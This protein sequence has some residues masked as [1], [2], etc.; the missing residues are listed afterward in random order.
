MGSRRTIPHSLSSNGTSLNGTEVIGS[1]RSP[2][3]S[4][5]SNVRPENRSTL[6]SVIAQLTEETQPFFEITLKSKAISENCN[7]K[8]LCVVT[9]YPVPQVTWYKDDIQLDRYCGLPKYEIF[10]NGQ[11]HSLHIYNCTVE[12][13]AIYQASATN[14]KGIVSCSGVLEVGEM[15]EFKIHQR[16]FS[17]LKQKAENKRREAQGKENQEPVRTISPDRAQRKRRSTVGGYISAPSSTE[18]DGTEEIQQK[19][20]AEVKVRTEDTSVKEVRDTNKTDSPVINGQDTK[21][22]CLKTGA[23]MYDSAQKIFT[24]L[25]PKSHFLKIKIT[26]T[27]KVPPEEKKPS[28]TVTELENSGDLM[29]V[30]G[31]S[32]SVVPALKSLKR[33]VT[34]I[35]SKQRTSQDKGDRKATKEN[36]NVQ[37][38]SPSS[39]TSPKTPSHTP[40]LH[41]PQPLTKEDT[42]VKPCPKVTDKDKAL[43]LSTDMTSQ[44]D[45][46]CD[47]RAVLPQPPCQQA[48][49]PLPQKETS[50]DQKKVRVAPPVP[51]REA[52]QAHAKTQRN[53]APVDLEH[54]AKPHTKAAPEKRLTE[55][56]AHDRHGLSLHHGP[57]KAIDKMIQDTPD[58]SRGS[59]E[60][61]TGLFTDTQKPPVKSPCAVEKSPKCN[62]SPSA[63]QSQLNT[64]IKI[65]EGTEIQLDEKVKGNEMSTL[66]A[67]STS[68]AVN[69]KCASVKS[70]VTPIS[71]VSQKEKAGEVAKE[72]DK[73]IVDTPNEDKETKSPGETVEMCIEHNQ[74]MKEHAP[75]TNKFEVSTEP[76][77]KDFKKCS[78][79]IPTI[80]SIAELLRSQINALE[81]SVHTQSAPEDHAGRDSGCS[82]VNKSDKDSETST[83][84]TQPPTIKETLMQIYN[85]LIKT[86]ELFEDEAP[87]L[88]NTQPLEIPPTVS[89]THGIIV[90]EQNRKNGPIQSNGIQV[91]E[92]GTEE[93]HTKVSTSKHFEDEPLQSNNTGVKNK[94]QTLT[95]EIKVNSEAIGVSEIITPFAENSKT[96]E[97]KTSIN[98][99]DAEQGVD[100][101]TEARNPQTERCTTEDQ[102]TV[103]LPNLT[104]E[105]SPIL[106]K[107]DSVSFPSATPQ[108][109]A[110][111][112][113]RKIHS[114]K[115]KP[116]EMEPS[117]PVSDLKPTTVT[118]STS[119]RL[120]RHSTLLQPEVEQASPK[121]KCSPLLSRKN[122]PLEIQSQLPVTENNDIKCEESCADKA[123]ND[124]YKAPQVI[125]KIR[126]ETF[127]DHSGH[128]KLW[129]QFFNVLNEST[130]IW[131]KDE[132][133]IA[134]I[135]KSAGDETQVKLA[136]A[137]AS[138]QDCGVYGCTITNEYGTDSTDFLLSAEVLNGMSLREDLGV[139]EEIEMTAL[140]FNK[141][142]ADSSMWGNKL[143]GRIMVQ[144]THLGAGFSH[145]TW[146]AKVIYGLEPVFES[147]NTCIIKVC[148]PIPYGGKG[149]GLLIE[150]NLEMVKQA[151]R[152]QNLTREYCKIFSA[153]TR[154]IEN[155]GSSLEVIPVYMMY[156]PAN[157]IPYA[158]VEADLTGVYCK[159]SGLGQSGRFE[160]SSESEVEKKCC[161]LQHWIFQWTNGNMMFTKLEGV[162]TKITNVHVS[163]KSSG[164]QGISLDANPKVFE[165]FVIQHQCNYFCGLL[166]LRSLKV[167]E[168]LLMPMKP[169]GS[170]SPLVQRKMASGSSSSQTGR[171]TNASPR[172][173]RKMEH[174]ERKS[175][176]EQKADEC[177]DRLSKNV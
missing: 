89:R 63:Q 39:T 41:P 79:P 151:C 160:V 139:G 2:G 65:I 78:S 118:V 87:S 149:E 132:L 134:K 177:K 62:V 152:I 150:K 18:E 58:H 168:S 109:L 147:G 10:R 133:E 1:S 115:S 119:P 69:E 29:E 117:A 101:S 130:L 174:G 77:S 116:E 67:E 111:G 68:V 91:S 19:I 70:D 88:T 155:F 93:A 146:R 156:R 56:T 9:G 153:E 122:S 137:Q 158:T 81:M 148:N 42:N 51:P 171:K 140:I 26:N 126:G 120:P 33:R 145:K 3:C 100:S 43:S 14:T 16:Y 25:K 127:T 44:S 66:I 86:K 154:A 75:V 20:D 159:Y 108:E 95:P 131:Y 172:T 6:C 96:D 128:L 97:L 82:S 124:S 170:K 47:S 12:D 59:S 34:S 32:A 7:V 138:C 52:T 125:R 110:S 36:L 114:S 17:K 84:K 169:K 61:C 83:E 142:V 162:D 22:N 176:S 90:F 123:R 175:P 21:E 35:G 173:P 13:A 5:L 28:V 105:T 135:I 24:A 53:D 92:M 30:E 45:T 136:L 143:F 50:S 129:C 106:R 121:K 4:Y 113:R 55:R 49:D 74:Q 31:T 37:N 15:N 54:Q 85:E 163:V 60:S 107:R 11:N 71:K 104:T 144:E 73:M 72:T 141:G 112:A 102:V 98:G 99:L 164:Y 48:R 166:G 40:K 76:K 57:Q 23:N 80:I 94:S 27:A 161:A 46:S 157:T 64:L 38:G 167:I 165:Q 103:P 8:F